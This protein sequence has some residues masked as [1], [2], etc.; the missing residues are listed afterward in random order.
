MFASI[1]RRQMA[2]LNGCM[3]CL[4]CRPITGKAR[5]IL[6]ESSIFMRERAVALAVG[7][8]VSRTVAAGIS[9]EEQTK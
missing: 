6:L 5:P 2:Y 1:V 4:V 3:T 7:Q 9:M 8:A